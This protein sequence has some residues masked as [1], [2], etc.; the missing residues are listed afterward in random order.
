[1]N[2]NNTSEPVFFFFSFNESWKQKLSTKC[3]ATAF[4]TIKK[5]NFG[6]SYKS[7]SVSNNN[8]WKCLPLLPPSQSFSHPLSH[9]TY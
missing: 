9:L 4:I 1:M 7:E 3:V 5:L 8:Q 2:E 6:L